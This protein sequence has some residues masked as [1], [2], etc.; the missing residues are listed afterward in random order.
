MTFLDDIINKLFPGR[1][2][3]RPVAVQEE[4][5]RSSNY[6]KTYDEWKNS[7]EAADLLRRVENSF[8]MKESQVEGLYPIHLF[9]SAAANGFALSYHPTISRQEF[10]YLMDFWRDR[11]LAMGYRLA[12]TD[13]Q[14]REKET[15]IQ[16][17][18]K[19]YLK[20]PL[21]RGKTIAEQRYGNIL[22]EYVLIDNEPSY[23]KVMVTTYTD[24]LYTKAESYDELLEMLFAPV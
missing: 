20:P 13:R 1:A 21:S 18:E 23:L 24:H 19:H 8:R 22:L 15:Y 16:T 5:H 17:T 7:P 9:N 3:E 14:I 6:L 4:L 11:V 2:N 10:H 12:N